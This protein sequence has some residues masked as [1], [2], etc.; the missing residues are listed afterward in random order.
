MKM[1]GMKHDM[2]ASTSATPVLPEGEALRNL[3]RLANEST[4][5][6]TFRAKL[7][8]QPAVARFAEGIDTP[9]V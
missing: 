5:P 7:A 1:D 4:A 2:G 3:T 9:M 8:A 6:G